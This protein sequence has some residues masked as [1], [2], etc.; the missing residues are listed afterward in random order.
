MNFTLR[1]HLMVIF[2]I[3]ALLPILTLGGIQIHRMMEITDEYKEMQ[4]QMN[5]R[6]ADEIRSYV[7]NHK[8]VIE[9]FADE[10]SASQHR[11]PEEL[12]ATLASLGRNFPGFVNLYAADQAGKNLA[13]YSLDAQSENGLTGYDFSTR[14][15]YQEIIAQ[16]QTV[17]SP[18]FQGEVTT[19]K[20]L[21]A[22]AAP[23]Y[24]GAGKFGGY[25]SA[26]L[27]LSE[28]KF[29][30]EKYHYGSGA[31]ALVLDQSGKV[32]YQPDGQAEILDLSGD[33]AIQMMQA[34]GGGTGVFQSALDRQEEFISFTTIEGLGWLV[35]VG[36]P[37]HIYREEFFQSLQ[38]I[39]V[40]LLGTVC[41]SGGLSWLLANLLNYPINLFVSYT[42]AIGKQNFNLYFPKLALWRM[43]REM[44]V[45][46][47]N[48]LMMAKQLEEKQ[49]AL[50]HLAAELETR[51]EERTDNLQAVLD[52]MSDAIVIVDHAEKIIYAN[53]RLDDLFGSA[54]AGLPG[55]SAAGFVQVLCGRV[56][57]EAAE[58]NRVFSGEKVRCSFTLQCKEQVRNIAIF[59]F[60]VTSTRDAIVL[61]RGYLCSDVTEKF[62]I[63]QLKNNL[64]SLAAH[65]FKTPLTGIRGSVETLLRPDIVWEPAF[66]REMLEGVLEDVLRIQLLVEDWLD[67]SKIDAKT[68]KLQKKV[69]SMQKLI[70]KVIKQLRRQKK[71]FAMQ[72]D[73][74]PNALHLYADDRRIE[75]V[76][77]NMV[78]NA[79]LY[80]G[81]NAQ[82]KITAYTDSQGYYLQIADCGEGIAKAH[83]AH[84]F[85]RFYRVEV[86]A[87]RRSGGTGLG[88]AICQGIIEAHGGHITVESEV[89]RGSTFMIFLPSDAYGGVDHA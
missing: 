53:H 52:S 57:D 15:Y 5:L 42:K 88:L 59:A 77:V 50:L 28:V 47:E 11:L 58:I 63:D 21:I 4:K 62:E 26:A 78:S 48:F 14:N 17:I 87:A 8:N 25:I 51:V 69:V 70:D 12:M 7:D 34:Q 79:I 85:E 22:I 89:G 86:T 23:I 39:V 55:Q 40:L 16:H 41:A 36:K 60:P 30:A 10:I 49:N 19:H 68:L 9:A 80:S 82:I 27:D 76:L 1:T 67:I 64:I 33:P 74:A 38:A 31:Y 75:Q 29:L 66:E 37:T 24:D 81:E 83:L 45:L 84:I 13:F 71:T 6:L 35:I 44:M 73:I 20:P 56:P 65:E 72:L 32:I 61:G 3:I 46:A 43:P 2:T 54:A 18:L